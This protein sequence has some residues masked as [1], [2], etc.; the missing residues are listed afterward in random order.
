MIIITII[1]I[2][3]PIG[4]YLSYRRHH[5]SELLYLF[6]YSLL[7]LIV[8]LWALIETYLVTV[9]SSISLVTAILQITTGVFVAYKGF[10]FTLKQIKS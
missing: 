1:F 6:K 8:N 10:R 4:I 7:A 2:L 9:P 3:L 5:D